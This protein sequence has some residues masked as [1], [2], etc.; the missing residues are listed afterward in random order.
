MKVRYI[1]NEEDCIAIPGASRLFLG[2][3][4]C[5]TLRFDEKGVWAITQHWKRM[6]TAAAALKIPFGCSLLR[7]QHSLVKLIEKKGLSIGGV[8][9]TLVNGAASRGLSNIASDATLMMYAFALKAASTNLKL[10]RAPWR[11]DAQNPVYQYKTINYLEAICAQ[12]YAREHGSDDVVF[13]DIQGCLTESS[14]AN[15]FC[16]K[17]NKLITPCLDG[18]VLP[19]IARSRI[20]EL[21]LKLGISVVEKKLAMEECLESEAIFLSNALY[22]VQPVAQFEG[23]TLLT[24]HPLVCRLI[25]AIEMFSPFI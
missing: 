4:L 15:L 14:V 21:A 16:I 20:I 2:E 3:G 6:Q 11:R 24:E 9:V 17:K 13:S 12:R 23:K 5:E 7:W 22:Y 10:I 8:K 18:S 19:G 1:E 25:A